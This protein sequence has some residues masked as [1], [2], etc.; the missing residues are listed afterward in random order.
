M[1]N[2]NPLSQYLNNDSSLFSFTFLL[3]LAIIFIL[4]GCDGNSTGVNNGESNGPHNGNS[5]NGNGQIGTSPTFD[6]VGQLFMSYCADC[7]TSTRQS[8]VRLNTY[9]NV[10]ESVGDQYGRLVVLPGD[11]DNSPLV[12]KIESSNPAFGVRMPEDGPYLSSQRIDQIKAWINNGAENTSGNGQSGGNGN[13]GGND[14]G[15]GY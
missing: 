8:G 9:T 5:Q 14:G 11:A 13:S 1:K 4:A 6:N 2:I 10:I 7:H 15:G 3:S 12:E